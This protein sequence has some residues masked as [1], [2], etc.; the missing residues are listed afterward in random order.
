VLVSLLLCANI[1]NNVYQSLAVQLFISLLRWTA[2]LSLQR[3]CSIAT[4]V[5]FS[6]LRTQNLNVTEWEKV[7]GWWANR[8]VDGQRPIEG[9]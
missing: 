9:V 4:G 7:A 6:R 5:P 1:A 8:Y 2:G 3:C